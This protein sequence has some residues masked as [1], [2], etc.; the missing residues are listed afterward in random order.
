MRRAEWGPRLPFPPLRK[1]PEFAEDERYSGAQKQQ[2]DPRKQALANY[3]LDLL[4]WSMKPLLNSNRV[5]NASSKIGH[6][7][8]GNKEQLNELEGLLRADIIEH[9]EQNHKEPWQSLS[10]D[11]H[12][13]F[14]ALLNN[15][16]EELVDRRYPGLRS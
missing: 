7:K 8:L 14:M 1:I 10:K 3:A 12:G 4:E 16:I 15:E 2:P 9:F 6:I 13:L 5:N 11:D